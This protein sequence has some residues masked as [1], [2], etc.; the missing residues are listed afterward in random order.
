MVRLK[1]QTMPE[2]ESIPYS[3][4]KRIIINC[5]DTRTQALIAYQYGLGCRAGELGHYYLHYYNN[6]TEKVITDGLKKTD[7]EFTE[8]ILRVKHPNFKQRKKP[9]KKQVPKWTGFVLRKQ[10]EWLF[11]IMLEWLFNPNSKG[12][13]VFNITR[14]RICQLIDSELKKYDE[15]YSSH[16]LRHSRATH[17]GELTGDPMAVQ[18]LLGHKRIDTSMRYVNYTEALLKRR[19]GEKNFEDVLG[20]VVE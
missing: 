16:W 11:N 9:D 5:K 15:R 1:G 8:E 12:E 18:K 19:L 13:Y 17:I 7:I 2:K 20:R 14:S 4:I 3:L 10:E 6:Q